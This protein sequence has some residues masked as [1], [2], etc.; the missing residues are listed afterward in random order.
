MTNKIKLSVTS[1]KHL[2]DGGR[3]LAIQ[4]DKHLR[5]HIFSIKKDSF[6]SLYSD[7]FQTKEDAMMNAKVIVSLS[8][9]KPL[10]V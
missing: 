10:L 3:V 7:G 6:K 4:E 1:Q 9:D 8:E 5:W 2:D